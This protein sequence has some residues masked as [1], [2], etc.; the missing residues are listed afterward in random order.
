[1]AYGQGTV[2]VKS[3]KTYVGLELESGGLWEK[4]RLGTR[5]ATADQGVESEIADA[6][7][8][9]QFE[10]FGDFE[11]GLSGVVYVRSQWA[12]QATL[13]PDVRSSGRR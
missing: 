3:K 11:G 12:D 10:A 8:F 4:R 5:G 13:H 2:A 9:A 6:G 7:D 1:M